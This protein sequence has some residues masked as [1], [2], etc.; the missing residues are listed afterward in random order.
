MRTA[1]LAASRWSPGLGLATIG[2][3]GRWSSSG[4]LAWLQAS[5]RPVP[6]SWCRRVTRTG[7]GQVP[8]RRDI[9]TAPCPTGSRCP[10]SRRRT[11]GTP[12]GPATWLRPQAGERRSCN[13]LTGGK[14]LR[15]SD[16]RTKP[17]HCQEARSTERRTYH[18]LAATYHSLRRLTLHYARNSTRHDRY[19]AGKRMVSDANEW[20]VRS[21]EWEVTPTAFAH[22]LPNRPIPDNA[23]ALLIDLPHQ[24][25]LSPATAVSST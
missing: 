19:V 17:S 16:T 6:A 23:G 20:E 22:S 4:T 25:D 12:A 5:R 9:V 8:P 14:S 1:W 2:R 11:L 7:S 15:A 18:S 10:R 3:S 21:N 13:T 24:L